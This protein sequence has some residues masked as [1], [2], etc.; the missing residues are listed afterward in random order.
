MEKAFTLTL[1][2]IT[3]LIASSCSR[4]STESRIAREIRLS[5]P[6]CPN[7]VLLKSFRHTFSSEYH[8]VCNFKDEKVFF[9]Y[10]VNTFG[11]LSVDIMSERDDDPVFDVKIN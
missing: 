5:K 3:A 9:Y 10:S 8:F 4:D 1:V 6:G 7:P 2:L 11:R